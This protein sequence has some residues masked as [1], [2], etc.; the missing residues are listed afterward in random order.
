MVIN[1]LLDAWNQERINM[2]NKKYQVFI[3]STYLDLKEERAKAMSAVLMSNCIP[4]VMEAFVA[5]DEEQFSV[6]KQIIDLCDFYVLI[7]GGRYG[8]INPATGKSYTEMEYDYA[9]SKGIPVLAFAHN[10]SSEI[11]K[12]EDEIARAK[13]TVFREKALKNRMS[14]MF[15]NPWELTA[16]LI[17]A[18]S[19]AKTSYNR[20]GWVRG[21]T[22]DENELMK[23]IYE[24]TKENAELKERVVKESEINNYSFL[25]ETIDLHFVETMFVIVSSN[26]R[27]RTKDVS[28]TYR[29][30]FLHLGPHLTSEI[31]L[32]EYKEAVNS[33]VQ[34]YHTSENN[35]LKIKSVFLIH[36]LFK[37]R[38][39]R[40]KKGNSTI[41]VSLSEEGMKLLASIN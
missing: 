4:A 34:G 14:G 41:M 26:T 16:K 17:A 12:D 27:I 38:N 32:F 28:P 33:Y 11:Q 8:S 29:E 1:V 36:G 3:S 22:Y 5:K 37:E 35:S 19:D 31:S 2:E 18:L 9:I 24:L 30:L 20:P 40:D 39:D 13:F 7:L 23:R 21:G 25:D 6:I 15:D 10:D